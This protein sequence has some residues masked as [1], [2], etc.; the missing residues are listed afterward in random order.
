M[1]LVETL[2]TKG[3]NIWKKINDLETKSKV[4]NI[5]DFYRNMY[6]FKKGCKPKIYLGNDENDNLVA[7][8][9]HTW[10]DSRITSVSCWM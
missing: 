10:T 5:T 2:G 1:N 4:K 3:G 8:S 7:D 9:H 6:E